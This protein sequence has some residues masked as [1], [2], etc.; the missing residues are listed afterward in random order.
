LQT[1]PHP[2]DDPPGAVPAAQV[3]GAQ[4]VPLAATVPLGQAQVPPHPSDFPF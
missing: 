1:P 4:Q 2:S 3:L